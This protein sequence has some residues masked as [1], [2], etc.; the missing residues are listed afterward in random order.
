MESAPVTFEIRDGYLL[1][2][3]TGQR[4][5]LAGMVNNTSLVYSKAVEVNRRKILLDGRGLEFHI[6]RT[7]AFNLIKMYEGKFPDSR[8]IKLAGVFNK[9]QFE[10]VSLWQEIGAKRGFEIKIFQD[11]SEAENWLHTQ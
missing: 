3:A 2:I 7:E 8:S 11:F 6:N 9:N 1:V 4:T 10:L 5:S